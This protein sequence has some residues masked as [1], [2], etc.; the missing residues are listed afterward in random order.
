MTKYTLAG[1]IAVIM[2]NACGP[3]RSAPAAEDV[4]AGGAQEQGLSV[5][6]NGTWHYVWTENCLDIWGRACTATFPS[7][8]CPSSNPEGM[9]CTIGP[10][11]ECYVT[12][13]G[14]SFEY[15]NCY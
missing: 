7:P 12:L 14:A 9:P 4:Q 10:N 11:F 8:Q 6:S 1:A 15:Y 5:S 13:T 2:L 3:S